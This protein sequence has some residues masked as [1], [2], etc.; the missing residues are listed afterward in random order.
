MADIRNSFR[1]N[2]TVK[3]TLFKVK[4][5]TIQLYSTCIQVFSYKPFNY[6]ML[7]LTLDYQF[8]PKYMYTL[9]Q[10]LS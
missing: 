9:N 4:H 2:E 8:L 5:Y 10:C 7:L 6:Y 3:A 1:H